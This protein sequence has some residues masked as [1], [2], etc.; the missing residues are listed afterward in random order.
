MFV[1]ARVLE[2]QD[3]NVEDDDHDVDE[4]QV[5]AHLANGIALDHDEIMLRVLGIVG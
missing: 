5:V 3:W 1:Q 4:Q 2:D